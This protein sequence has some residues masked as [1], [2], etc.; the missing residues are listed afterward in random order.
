MTEYDN[1]KVKTA[2]VKPVFNVTAYT[3]CSLVINISYHGNII[4]E[5]STFKKNQYGNG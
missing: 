1:L 3:I 2:L 5:S 4:S